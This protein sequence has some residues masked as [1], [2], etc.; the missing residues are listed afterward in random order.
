MKLQQ[1][2]LLLSTLCNFCRC[3]KGQE[4]LGSKVS[5]EPLKS[6]ISLYILHSKV[7][8]TFSNK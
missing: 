2:D 6:E 5:V 8:K 4:A 7:I 3:L 1:F